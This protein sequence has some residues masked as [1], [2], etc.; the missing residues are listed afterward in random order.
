[1]KKEFVKHLVLS[2]SDLKT[3]LKLIEALPEGGVLFVVTEKNLLLGSLTD[4]DIRRSMIDDKVTLKTTVDEVMQKNPKFIIE[5]NFNV[6]KII[7][8]RKEMY[9]VVPILS[10]DNEI[11]GVL[12]FNQIRN[13]L[14]IDVVVMAGGKGKRL[15]PITNDLPKPMIKVDGKPI[16]EHHLSSLFKFGIKNFWITTNYLSDQITDYFGDGRSR[17]SS[18]QYIKEDKPLG[19]IGSVSLINKFKS[20]HVL[21]T[22]ADLLSNISYEDFYID[23]LKSESDIS[24]LSIPYEVSIPFGVLKLKNKKIISI[25]EKPRYEYLTNGGVYLFKKN[26]L[27]LIPENTF[28]N[29]TDL[30]AKAIKDGYKVDK[31]IFN[32]YWRDIGRIEDLEKVRLEYSNLEV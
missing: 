1:M 13:L 22:N 10:K 24:I 31:Y 9:K 5:N 32:G 14:P 26:I 25:S 4:G 12:N 30:I 11:K 29:A 19:T 28:F 21:I 20:N 8:L 18:I 6:E 3:A 7:N 27:S 17:G 23:F 16:L 15:R 2:G